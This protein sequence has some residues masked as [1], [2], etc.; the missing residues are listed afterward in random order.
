MAA[1]VLSSPRAQP[2]MLIALTRP[3]SASITRCELTHLQRRPINLSLAA[4]QHE[5]YEAALKTLGCTVR[6]LPAEHDLPDAVFVEDAAVIVDECAVITRPGAASRRPETTSVAAALRRYR[7]LY[8]VEAPGTLDGG[9]VLRVG[10]SLYLGVS[11]RTNNDGA[12]QLE[13]L[14]APM[15]YTVKCSSVRGCLHLK[16]AASV[17]DGEEVLLN[18]ALV[19]AAIF[20]RLKWIEVSPEEPFSANVLC[21]GRKVLCPASAPRT[22][23]RLRENGYDVLAVDL[24]E[25]AK[26]EGGLTCC[27]LVFGV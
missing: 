1:R 26:A 17:L 9:D 14:L 4:K 21:I 16:S 24:S 10:R 27:S 7:S 23:E 3:V 6:R 22:R 20:E 13:H 15:G 2:D 18:P 12:K 19:D 11:G 5:Q 8:H 25:V